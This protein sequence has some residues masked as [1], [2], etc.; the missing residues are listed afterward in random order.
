VDI[1]G[2]VAC[3]KNSIMRARSEEDVRV[4]VSRCIEELIL[5]PLG[6][7]QVGKYVYTLISGAR[8]D[9]LYVPVVIE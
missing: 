6:I 7:M 5:K 3:F 4:W 2:I 1:D 8:V 9:A